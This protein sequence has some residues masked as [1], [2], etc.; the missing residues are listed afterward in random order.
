VAAAVRNWGA[1]QQALIDEGLRVGLT[2]SEAQQVVA[3]AA[4]VMAAQGNAA[5]QPPSK[6]AASAVMRS[7]SDFIKLVAAAV[8]NWGAG[9]QALIDEG[10]RMGLT[11]SQAQQVVAAAANVIAEQLRV[12]LT[13]SEAQQVVAA[14]ANAITAQGNAA[15]QSPSKPFATVTS[16]PKET[17]M[18]TI[19]RQPYA[20]YVFADLVKATKLRLSQNYTFEQL[21]DY[22]RS[23]GL[24]DVEIN[25]VFREA[26]ASPAITTLPAVP[27]TTTTPTG[28][29][30]LLP[31]AL[32]V[33]SYF[34]LS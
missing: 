2:L 6:P 14:A 4:N 26:S 13:L 21:R 22:A 20:G 9:Q 25:N 12:G 10:L 16:T 23:I 28:G 17:V 3:A 19:Q 15:L 24:T 5:L 34:L 31:I 32:A 7:D 18:A 8:R 33:A 1:G 27:P 29:T 30:N 11:L